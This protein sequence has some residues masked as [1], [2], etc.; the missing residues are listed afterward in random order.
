MTQEIDRRRLLRLFESEAEKHLEKLNNGL[1]NLKKSPEDLE[2]IKAVFRETHTLKGSAK[3][4]GIDEISQISQAVEDIFAN[5]EAKKIKFSSGLAD[6]IFKALD[7][8]KVFVDKTIKNEKVDI[9]F[10][11]ICQEL[12]GIITDC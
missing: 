1:L 7:L 2:Q 12:R 10:S 5:L 9:D 8:I 4:L 3:L 11:E 6:S